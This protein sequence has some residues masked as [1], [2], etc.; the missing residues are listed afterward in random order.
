M[1]AD[2]RAGAG[3]RGRRGL[4]RG[5]LEARS[6]EEEVLVRVAGTELVRL[7][8]ATNG[9]DDAAHTPEAATTGPELE[10]TTRR[11]KPLFSM[12]A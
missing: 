10:R 1:D 8:V 4:E 9:A 12:V 6:D 5:R 11:G 3:V 7:D 2:R